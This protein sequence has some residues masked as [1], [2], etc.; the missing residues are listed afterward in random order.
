MRNV[1]GFENKF[2]VGHIGSFS[3]PKNHK[4][5]IEIFHQ[6]SKRNH[7]S[8]L[9]LIGDG[10]L[11]PKIQRTV[12]KLGLTENVVFT[13]VRSDIPELLQAMD[14][15]VFPSLFE[16]L[17]I[18]LVEAQAAGLKVIASDTIT[19]EIRLT[20]LVELISLRQS[21]SHWAEKVLQYKGGYNRI[22]V[23]PEISKAGYDVE[24]EVNWLE[25]FYR[26]VWE[27]NSDVGS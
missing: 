3:H 19:E 23:C 18:T 4:F 7:N 9:L 2:T 14:I 10:E 17:P 12:F 15:L 22:N 13:G 26:M 6:I 27:N 21:A 16:G 11:R 1:L 25:Q 24:G 5:L 8:I 20:D